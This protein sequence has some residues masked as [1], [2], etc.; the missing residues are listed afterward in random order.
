MSFFSFFV[1]VSSPPPPPAVKDLDTE[2]YVHLVSIPSSV[3]SLVPISTRLV[4]LVRRRGAALATA[5]GGVE[6]K[7]KAAERT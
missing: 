6:V 5:R 1:V 7:T 3:I 4:L 2:K